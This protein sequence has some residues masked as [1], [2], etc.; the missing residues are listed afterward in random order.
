MPASSR[1]MGRQRCCHCRPGA[2][3][4]SP[5]AE[6]VMRIRCTPSRNPWDRSPACSY[7][8]TVAFPTFYNTGSLGFETRISKF[9]IP[10]RWNLLVFRNERTP[11]SEALSGSFTNARHIPNTHR[12]VLQKEVLNRQYMIGLAAEFR[13]VKLWM[14]VATAIFVCVSGTYP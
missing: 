11:Q 3:I 7:R 2:T 5:G 4:W 9:T 13:G 8:I 10:L 12:T 1:R 6:A 14:K